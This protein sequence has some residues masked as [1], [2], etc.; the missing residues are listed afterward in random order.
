MPL[1]MSR[2]WDITECGG[3]YEKRKPN[4]QGWLRYPETARFRF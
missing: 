4:R 1:V 2:V 3:G